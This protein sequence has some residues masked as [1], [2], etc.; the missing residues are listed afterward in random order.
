MVCSSNIDIYHICDMV[1]EGNIEGV[2]SSLKSHNHLLHEVRRGRSLLHIAAAA[3]NID[4]CHF[5]LSEG[6]NIDIL[7][8]NLMTPLANTAVKGHFHVAEFLLNKGAA[9]DGDPRGK[10][11]PLILASQE[12]HLN[13]VELLLNHGADINRLQ[14]NLNC[15]A[16]DLAISYNRE[17]I[18]YFLKNQG[19]KTSLG[20]INISTELGSGIIEHIFN[21]VG[22]ILTDEYSLGNSTLKTA[23]VGKGNNN[24]LLFTFGHFKSHLKQEF[25]ICLPYDW[26]L[27][28][29]IFDGNYKEAFPLKFFYHCRN[30]ISTMIVSVKV[31]FL[32][33]KINND[34]S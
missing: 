23:L 11:S 32:T 4:L 5:F 33:K 14:I 26:P 15:T 25:L 28:K 29:E 6:I 22:P 13:I 16:L 27:N 3:G 9:V 19:A 31:I 34:V 10:T 1:D 18:I 17:N 8:D 20:K 12:G 30:I 21:N 7:D 2:K 24:K